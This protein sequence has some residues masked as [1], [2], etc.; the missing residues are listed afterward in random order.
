M[1]IYFKIAL[2]ALLVLCVVMALL[3]VSLWFVETLPM[4][5]RCMLSAISICTGVAFGAITFGLIVS[6]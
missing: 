5:V 3:G 2:G 1:D 6:D 4:I